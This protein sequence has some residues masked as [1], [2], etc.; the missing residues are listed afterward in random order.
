MQIH[1][2]SHQ[3]RLSSSLFGLTSSGSSSSWWEERIS[4]LDGGLIRLCNDWPGP[5]SCEDRGHLRG[6]SRGQSTD[7]KTAARRSLGP[8]WEIQESTPSKWKE[9][10]VFLKTSIRICCRQPAFDTEAPC[11]LLSTGMSLHPLHMRLTT[12]I[13]TTACLPLAPSNPH[14]GQNEVRVRWVRL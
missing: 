14:L 12:R 3:Q 7:R 8:S 1:N 13:V 6:A 4:R 10:L 2:Q 11:K 9:H 5:V